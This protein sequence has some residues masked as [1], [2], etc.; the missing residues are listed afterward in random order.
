MLGLVRTILALMVMV[1]HLYVQ[2]GP[3]G[4]FSVFGFYIISGYLMT[5]V[6][7]ESYGY[8]TVGKL[9][10][11]RNRFLRLYPSYWVA[12]GLSLLLIGWLG[13]DFAQRYHSS[14]AVPT[15][16]SAVVWNLSMVFPAW[17]P[18]HV[19]PRLVPPAWALT[20]ELFFYALICLGLSR[21]PSRVR[22]WLLLSV[23]FVAGSYILGL[24]PGDRYFTAAAAS[25]PFPSVQ[26]CISFVLTGAARAR[27]IDFACVL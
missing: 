20:V 15:S 8:T 13:E 1:F 5:M 16:A 7:N 27:W 18:E 21:N 2:I 19:N 10:F 26:P 9:A 22:C 11:A 6:M 14:L 24:H 4:S 23:G 12:A 17:R 25:L 3:L